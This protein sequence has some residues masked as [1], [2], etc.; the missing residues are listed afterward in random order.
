MNSKD[1]FMW[2]DFQKVGC[3]DFEILKS[4]LIIHMKEDLDHHSAIFIREQADKLIEQKNV[5]NVI[6]DFSKVSFMDSSGIG[7]IMG[8]YKKLLHVGGG[9]LAV[10]GVTDRIDR[11]LKLSGLYKIMSRY[12]DMQEA[13]NCM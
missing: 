3:A 10:I 8:R 5:K 9:A 7:V 12:Q 1:E 11:I 2:L 4:T 6:F 13:L